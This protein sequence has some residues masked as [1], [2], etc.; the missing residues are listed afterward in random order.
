MGAP[1]KASVSTLKVHGAFGSLLTISNTLKLQNPFPH[2]SML[3]IEHRLNLLR[4]PDHLKPLSLAP[5]PNKPTAMSQEALINYKPYKSNN[6]PQIPK[7]Q[8]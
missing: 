6:K 4:V 7:P 1:F 5:K 8:P 3:D 2:V